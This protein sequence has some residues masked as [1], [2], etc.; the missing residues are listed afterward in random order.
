MPY[1]PKCGVE[2]DYQIKKCPL[3]RFPIPKI[4]EDMDDSL[5]ENRFPEPEN[6]YFD[7]I[8]KMKN[9]A[10]F[11]ISIL[12]FS[13]VLILMAI[14]SIIP[15]RP[16]AIT[17]SIICVISSWFYI[18]LLFGYIRN[19]YYSI[20]GMALTT[21]C[22]T[23]GLDNVDGKLTWY[24]S[25]AYPII[26]LSVLILFLIIYL[27]NRSRLKNQFIFVPTYLSIGISLFSVALECILDYQANRPIQLSWSLIV[28]IVLMS[29]A[30]LL[31]SLYYKLPD[32]LK[33]KI[34]RKLHI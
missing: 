6:I 32:R 15:V 31:I 13:A 4:S 7:K 1:C 29:I 16:I 25:Y 27:Y 24:Y 28:F 11:C 18:F 26:L 19:R 21:F 17:Y 3:C 2:L 34:K 20:L 8:L 22:L 30:L 33:E 9:Q 12:L 5:N 14:D 10:F 23:F